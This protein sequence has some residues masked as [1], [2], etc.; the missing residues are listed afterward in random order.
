MLTNAP[1]DAAKAQLDELSL[2]IKATAKVTQ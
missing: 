2:R 1:S